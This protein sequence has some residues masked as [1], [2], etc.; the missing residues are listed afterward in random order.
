MNTAQ[1]CNSISL[2]LPIMSSLLKRVYFKQTKDRQTNKL[3]CGRSVHE[4][5][6]DSH[7]HLGGFYQRVAAGKVRTRFSFKPPDSI[8]HSSRYKQPF[9]KKIYVRD[10]LWHLPTFPPPSSLLVSSLLL[11]LLSFRCCAYS[12][13]RARHGRQARDLTSLAHG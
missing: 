13:A 9:R 1:E 3:C 7:R 6:A 12:N 5:A 4:K 11:C 8:I 2:S 10:K